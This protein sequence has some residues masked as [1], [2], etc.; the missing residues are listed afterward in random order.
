MIHTI[1]FVLSSIFG[2]VSPIPSEHF[3]CNNPSKFRVIHIELTMFLCI[4]MYGVLRE[5]CIN[6]T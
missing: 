3:R 2:V 1:R 4:N 6:I 5:L